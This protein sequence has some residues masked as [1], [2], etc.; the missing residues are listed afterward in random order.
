[1][2]NDLKGKTIVVTGA[3]QGV[4]NILYILYRSFV[5]VANY[6]LCTK[7]LFHMA[8]RMTPFDVFWP[9]SDIKALWCI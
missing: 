3:G 4:Q 1:M 2:E 9:N 8:G 6:F 7:E 5:S